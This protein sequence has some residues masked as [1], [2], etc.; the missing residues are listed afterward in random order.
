MMLQIQHLAWLTL[1]STGGVSAQASRDTVFTQTLSFPARIGNGSIEAH[2]M[3]D[4]TRFWYVGGQPGQWS[5][6]KYDPTRKERTTLFDTSRVR[7]ALAK[8]TGEELPGTALPFNRITL[9][10]GERTAHFQFQGHHYVLQ[11]ESSEIREETRAEADRLEPRLLSKA[12]IVGPPRVYEIPS[13][14]D[15][16]FLG[17]MD[18][19]L[20]LR[21]INHSHLEALTNDAG[22]DF[23][24]RFEWNTL[25]LWSPDSRLIAVRRTDRLKRQE[26]VYPIVHWLKVVPEVEWAPYQQ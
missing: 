8:I 22:K 13:P 1:L 12:A 20:Y 5:F 15:R 9:A 19:N 26:S 11:M 7:N 23:G 3:E 21:S 10:R 2:W 18:D 6:Y 25:P 16:W 24:W 14:D 4:G 17:A